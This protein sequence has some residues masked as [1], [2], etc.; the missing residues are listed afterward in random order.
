MHNLANSVLNTKRFAFLSNE[1][2][3]AD[4]DAVFKVLVAFVPGLPGI[5][6]KLISSTL[7]G[8]CYLKSDVSD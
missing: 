5:V 8:S 1:S 7:L 6:S 3:F 4:K 2:A